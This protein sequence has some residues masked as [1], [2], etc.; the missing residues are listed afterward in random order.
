MNF[1]ELFK[2]TDI[3]YAY[4]VAV[5]LICSLIIIAQF[6]LKKNKY[7]LYFFYVLTIAGLFLLKIYYRN[8]STSDLYWILKPTSLFT[9]IMTGV[10]FIYHSTEGFVSSYL[11]ITIDKSCAGVNF[12]ILCFALSIYSVLKHCKDFKGFLINFFILLLTCYGLTIIANS[13]RI[14]GALILLKVLNPIGSVYH[15][16][17]RAEGIFIYLII[18]MLFYHF[19]NKRK[20]IYNKKRRQL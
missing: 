4:L 1:S 19:L 15:W 18:L 20:I 17:H 16:F 6:V 8:S 5:G 7:Y 10:R 13:I 14:T 3:L 2:N 12:F 11:D 9:T